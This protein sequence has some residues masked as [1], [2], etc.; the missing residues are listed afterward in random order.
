MTADRIFVQGARGGKSVINVLDRAS[1]KAIWSKALGTAGSN[2]RGSGPR[3]T[4][5]L[6]GDRVYVLS[7]EGDL[8][9]LGAANGAEVWTR[10]ILREFSGRQIPWLISESPLVDGGNVIVTPGG[11]RATIV[12]LEKTTGKTVWTSQ[13]LS[14][15]AGYASP[16]AADVGGVRV[17]MTLTSR[18]GVGVRASDGRLMWRFQPVA[19]DTANI[20]TPI[21]H[22][23]KVFYSTGY[24]TGAALLA[25]TANNGEVA[26]QQV[27][28]TRDMQ[29]HHGGLVLVDGYLYGFHNSILACLD[30]AT[31]RVVWRDRSVGKGTLTY[32]D[33]NL[34]VLSENNVVGLVAASPT[35][36]QEKGR[37]SIPDKG[38]PSWAHPVVS[39]GTL[40]LRN[41]D[42][43]MAF[44]VRAR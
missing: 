36:Y 16:I 15:A 27:Y 18:A 44:D 41:Q 42:T 32:A 24:G 19:N 20:A 2:D 6:D 3:G 39:G 28:F 1:G 9:C 33:G 40:Y 10:N 21:F 11:P 26:A 22:D 4:P 30:F 29:N 8:W 25:L 37:F 38:L 14:D 13:Q 5:T 35:G 34:Y 12:A 7:E 23:N 43:L 17:Y 31:G